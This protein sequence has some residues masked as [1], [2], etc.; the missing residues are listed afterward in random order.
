LIALFVNFKGP[1]FTATPRLMGDWFFVCI[2]YFVPLGWI[3]ARKR[4]EALQIGAIAVGAVTTLS[5]LVLFG[6]QLIAI[7]KPVYATFITPM[8]AKMEQTYW[9]KLEPKALIFDPVV[10]R[11]P[12]VF[13][14]FTDSSPSWYTK[15][16]TWQALADAP[17]PFKLH[18]AGFDYMYFD[19]DY[20]NSLTAPEQTLFSN[21]C[22]KQIA[23]V[24][25]IHSEK[26]YTKDFRRL[27]SIR[28]CK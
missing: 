3:W 1:L 19:S 15:S 5:G 28:N 22:V 2:L 21:S 9:D 25:G 6:V 24:D 8:D 13:A 11:A 10:F 4:S 26:D 23:Q 18:A 27:L 12:T 20:W 16:P 7:Q 17:D 14:R